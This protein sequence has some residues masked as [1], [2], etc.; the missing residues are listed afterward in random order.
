MTDQR[1]YIDEQLVDI[2]DETRLT[3]VMKSNLFQDVSKIVSNN[4]FSVKLPKT[5]R[6]QRI[7][8]HADKTNGGDFPYTLH[9][10]R[11]FRNGVEIIRDGRAVCLSVGD[12]IEIS[13]VW[14]LYPAFAALQS[15]GM[16]LNQLKSAARL[17]W[18]AENIHDRYDDALAQG[19]FYADYNTIIT[20]ERSYDWSGDDEPEGRRSTTILALETGAVY[21]GQAVGQQILP[22]IDATQTDYKAVVARFS[23]GQTLKIDGAVGGA[24][25]YRLYAVLDFNNNILELGEAST[26][27]APAADYTIQAPS[28]AYRV[29]VN[30]LAARSPQVEVY[31]EEGVPNES[32]SALRAPAN[33]QMRVSFYDENIHPSVLV[34]W[35]LNLI[36]EQTGV[37]FK[38]TGAAAE[39]VNQL[40]IPLISNKST[41]AAAD[42]AIDISLLPLSGNGTLNIQLNAAT[43]IFEQQPGTYN[44][45]HVVSNA[46]VYF[47]I[48]GRWSWDASQTR[49]TGS[50]TTYIDGVPVTTYVYVYPH[51]YVVMQVFNTNI[52]PVRWEQYIIGDSV[53]SFED[54][55][56]DLVDGRFYRFITGHGK[57]DLQ[58]GDTVNFYMTNNR[59]ELRDV[60][61]HGGTA[62]GTVDTGDTVPRG[63]YFPIAY[64]LP[65]IK[66]IDFV[67][68]LAAI[69]GTFPVQHGED[70]AVTFVPFDTLWDNISQ[71][72]DWTRR[73]VAQGLANKPKEIEF[74]AGEYAQRNEYHWKEDDT[75]LGNYDGVLYVDNKTLDESKVI[76][77]FPFAASDGNHV[78]M[79]D[80]SGEGYQYKACKDRIMQLYNDGGFAALRFGLNMQDIIATRYKR[81]SEA[82]QRARAIKERMML[83]DVDLLNFDER[84]PVYLSQYSAYFAVTEIK[85]SDAGVADVTMFQISPV[86]NI[87]PTNEVTIT[88]TS[89][90]TD[91]TYSFVWNAS[92]P[93]PYD[94]ILNIT[95]ST[96]DADI[97]SIQL[98]AGEQGGTIDR[99]MSADTPT[100]AYIVRTTAEDETEYSVGLVFGN[101][102]SVGI[103]MGEQVSR[104]SFTA[105]EPLPSPITVFVVVVGTSQHQTTVTIPAGATSGEVPTNDNYGF[106]ELAFVSS[107]CTKAET[108]T[109]EYIISRI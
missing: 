53:R 109:N 101:I 105:S 58:V 104:L 64:N 59:G 72:K 1:L 29:V 66:I 6:N 70:N 87:T 13:I 50:T 3:L 36:W 84:V 21:T 25:D 30:V 93:L 60:Q 55:S 108:D 92:E 81:L 103:G 82:L 95:S 88:V 99:V 89:T 22:T 90:L 67:K 19:Y 44:A 56:D 68:F 57:I 75:V 52:S 61:F 32:R 106:R 12:K 34:S 77:T 54:Y 15:S 43:P 97:E 14:G 41:S 16:T 79:Y 46:S 42:T 78:P 71:A 94:L 38:W 26:A 7:F 62:K 80:A 40:A 96:G 39:L 20:P 9:K 4:T 17:R 98:Q 74:K 63:G 47:D 37:L 85:L 100:D 2:D 83:S 5:V 11:Y 48:Q 65:N 35:L 8:N 24:D 51:N 23:A 33:N 49:P 69:T 18:P 10:A 91:G 31:I 107:E 28:E 86:A 76:I 102:I 45:L 73:L 27:G